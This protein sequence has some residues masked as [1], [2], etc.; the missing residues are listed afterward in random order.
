[1]AN[2]VAF[3]SP[4]TDP[5]VPGTLT[6]VMS[7]VPS[8]KGYKAAPSP[9]QSALPALD[10][11]CYGAASLKRLDGVTRFFAGTA[12]SL[13]E[14]STGAWLDVTRISSPYALTTDSR[15]CYAQ[16]GNTSLAANKSTP[17]QY[18]NSGEFDDIS[19]A[20][21]AA[22][23]DVVN[24]F[25]FAGNTSD[26]IYGDSPDR[27]WW[28]ALGDY[29]DWTPSAATQAGTTRATS[30]AGKV[31]A[32]KRFGSSMIIYKAESMFIA[33]YVGLPLI[34]DVQ[35]IQGE[36]GTPCQ[37]TVVNVGTPDYPRHIFMGLTDFYQF[38][39]GQPSPIG[40][41]LKETV[42]NEINNASIENSYAMHD[43]INSRVYFY[44][45]SGG[46]TLPNKCVVY[47]YKT[48]KWG[49]DD[50]GI[51]CAAE[52]VSPAMTYGDL[53]DF[54]STYGD[55]PNVSYGSSIFSTSA[56]VP[57]IF[58][59][60]HT[61]YSLN[62][63]PGG[64]SFT[65]GDYGDEITY[66]MLKRVKPEFIVAPNG[67]SM[68]NYYR[69]SLGDALSPDQ[70]VNMSNFRFDILRSARWHRI[71]INMNGDAE[72]NSLAAIFKGN[73]NE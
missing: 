12:T 23:I 71:A 66:K 16:Y 72:L 69:D 42:F 39:G 21:S 36:I 13:L 51:E 54:Y 53:G 55:L 57:A 65:T 44:Y 56:D 22:V 45:P 30:K 31:T 49:R 43:R 46:A 41:P 67:A 14:A 34:W 59:T 60:D 38:G 50:R 62:G 24:N 15:W 27:V 6:D 32:V 58:S 3:Y 64:S 37:N 1:M 61:L 2:E 48:N 7:L 4:D 19:G 8:M 40:S 18:S 33:T 10:S 35:D 68:T 63:V 17:I 11:A 20:P 47:N 73:G 26:G 9:I 5:T 70:T 25:V 52:F 28:S 29:S